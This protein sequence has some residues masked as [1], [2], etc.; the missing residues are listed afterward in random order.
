MRPLESY[1]DETWDRFFDFIA[2]GTKDLTAEEVTQ[3]LADAGIDMA[4]AHKRLRKMI[5]RQKEE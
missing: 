4:P 2:E 5:D 3:A 1:G